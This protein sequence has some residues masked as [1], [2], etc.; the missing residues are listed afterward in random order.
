MTELFD[1][2]NDLKLFNMISLKKIVQLT[3]SQYNETQSREIITLD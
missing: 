2:K 3:S 1:L